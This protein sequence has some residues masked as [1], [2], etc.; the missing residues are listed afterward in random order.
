ML[1]CS[2]KN[3]MKNAKLEIIVHNAIL[4][5]DDNFKSK[6]QIYQNRAARI[7]C[8]YYDHDIHGIDLVRYL[9]WHTV[10]DRIKYFTSVLMFKCLNNMVPEYISDGFTFF[11]D[12]HQHFTRISTNGG[13]LI[14]KPRTELYKQSL[15]FAGPSVWNN[16]QGWSKPCNLLSINISKSTKISIIIVILVKSTICMNILLQLLYL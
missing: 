16:L 3:P 9:G 6:L 8:K 15:Y 2:S 5:Q 4:E 11:S 14:P 7:V 1:V 13:L 10:E 12:I